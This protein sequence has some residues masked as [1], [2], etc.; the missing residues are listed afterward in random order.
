M[1]TSSLVLAFFVYQ[2]GE[3][4]AVIETH[5]FGALILTTLV[6]HLFT[7]KGG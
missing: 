4:L 2:L 6:I 1:P 3:V 5:P 7:H